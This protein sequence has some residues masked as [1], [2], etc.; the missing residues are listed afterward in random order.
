M[1][2]R[3]EEHLAYVRKQSDVSLEKK[4]RTGN[5]EHKA[6]LLDMPI[7][8]LLDEALAENSDQRVYLLTIKR[9]LEYRRQEDS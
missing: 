1:R 2:E 5:I 9:K 4:F 8:Q 7:E 6:D 3:D